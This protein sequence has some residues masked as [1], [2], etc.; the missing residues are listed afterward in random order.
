MQVTGRPARRMF[1]FHRAS[2]IRLPTHPRAFWRKNMSNSSYTVP[3]LSDAD[4][5]RT[6]QILQER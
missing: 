4:G 2:G 3:G 1:E 6:A 5:S